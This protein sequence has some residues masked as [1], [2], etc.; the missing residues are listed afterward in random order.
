[1]SAPQFFYPIGHSVILKKVRD[2]FLPLDDVFGLIRYRN[3]PPE[4]L[5]FPI[6]PERDPESGK[7]WF[8]LN[9]MPVF[10]SILRFID[11]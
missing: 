5:Y 10:G 9:V 1:M 4:Y 6:L 7:V 3:C 11:I 2:E 8:H